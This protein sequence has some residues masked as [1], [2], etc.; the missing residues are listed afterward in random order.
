[1]SEI[2]RAESRW[3]LAGLNYPSGG[4]VSKVLDIS[5]WF[6]PASGLDCAGY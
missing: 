4:A 1:M 6:T 5:K 2:R 3:A